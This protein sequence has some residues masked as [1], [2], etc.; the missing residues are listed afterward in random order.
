M[1]RRQNY[2]I[3]EPAYRRLHKLKEMATEEN[4]SPKLRAEI[5]AIIDLLKVRA[6]YCEDQSTKPS[7]DLL[8]LM[9]ATLHHQWKDAF[10]QGKLSYV[11]TTLMMSGNLEAQFLR[12]LSSLGNARRVL[13]LGLFTGCTALALAESIPEDGKVVSCELDPYIA[14]L[15]RSLLDKTECGKKVDIMLGDARESM[16]ALA[17]KKM[18]FD[19]IFIDADKENYG[20]YYKMIWELGL[21]AP[22]GMI[23]VDNALFFG[24][25]YTKEGY[26]GK[27]G[28]G[29]TNFNDIVR[30]DGNVHKILV[31]IRDGLMII[32]RIQDVNVHK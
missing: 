13:E 24:D 4:V 18:Q 12:S 20:V 7:E 29:I 1:A 31:P 28:E 10:E 23:L 25:P 22:K 32:R 8:R 14:D 16:R 21:L 3:L 2:M 26:M 19:L 17:D 6:D 11:P 5:D 27:A 9:E 30:K 15:A